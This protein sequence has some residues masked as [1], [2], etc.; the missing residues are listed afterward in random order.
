M[1]KRI[2]L[3]LSLVSVLSAGGCARHKKD[4]K[5]VPM[6]HGVTDIAPKGARPA[7][8]VPPDPSF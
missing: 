8:A 4:D 1:T 7:S 5:K 6:D 2:C 3:A